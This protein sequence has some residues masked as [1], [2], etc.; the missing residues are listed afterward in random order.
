ME[1]I[2]KNNCLISNRKQKEMREEKACE[3]LKEVSS[4]LF[5]KAVEDSREPF[6]LEYHINL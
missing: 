5:C 2:T 3:G 1:V 6:K 4:V